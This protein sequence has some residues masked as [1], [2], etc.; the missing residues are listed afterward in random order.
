LVT[1]YFALFFS[2]FLMSKLLFSPEFLASGY[3]HEFREFLSH[4]IQA[5]SKAVNKR[6]YFLGV[7]SKCITIGREKSSRRRVDSFIF[8]TWLI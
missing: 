5:K 8:K 6:K 4:I 7:D 1:G 2:F 3:S